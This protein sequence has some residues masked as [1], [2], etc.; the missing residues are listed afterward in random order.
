MKTILY[1]SGYFT[2]H[3]YSKYMNCAVLQMYA[4]VKHYTESI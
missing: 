3:T 4:H 1:N 2:H